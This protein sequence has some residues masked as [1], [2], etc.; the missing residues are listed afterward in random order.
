MNSRAAEQRK[1]ELKVGLTIFVGLGILIAAIFSI[2][3]QRGLL[4]DRYKLYVFMARV[5]GLQTGAPV[6]LAGVRVGTIVNIQFARDVKDQ[7]IRV[8]MEIDK[9][10][11]ARIRAD[12]EAHIGTLGLLGDKYIGISMGSFDKPMLKNGELL[13]S[14]NPIDVEKLLTEGMN[15]FNRLE[16][17]TGTIQEIADKINTGKGTLGLLVNDPRMYINI[18]KLLLLVESLSLKIESGEGS[19]ARIFQ[20]STL[21]V[22]L[23]SLAHNSSLLADSLRRGQGT[24]GK[25]I[26]DPRVFDDFVTSLDRLNR[27]TA[28]LESGEGA[29]GQ[30]LNNRKLYDDLLH[31]T[32]ELDSL[33]KDIRRNPQRYLKVEIF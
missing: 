23:N 11:Q 25:F 30:A 1:H 10:V 33:I 14:S 6:R 9:K 32:A 27:M 12:S 7:A 17:T 2:G 26:R 8:D 15:I 29:L 20:D 28:K 18:D 19:L 5:N 4:E 31:V 22:N 24:V 13:K 16:K 3:H 21:Y